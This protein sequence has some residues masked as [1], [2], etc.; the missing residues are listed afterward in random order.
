LLVRRQPLDQH[1][2]RRDR[3]G[4]AVAL[5]DVA[6]N[7]EPD[8]RNRPR[9]R[10]STII[11]AMAAYDRKALP[12]TG[13]NGGG[14]RPVDEVAGEIELLARQVDRGLRRLRD[15]KDENRRVAMRAT[16]GTAIGELDGVLVKSLEL[17]PPGEREFASLG[18]D[19]IMR[20]LIGDFA[21][22]CGFSSVDA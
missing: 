11:R 15:E 9:W 5:R 6:P 18:V 14:G 10:L 21:A 7:G 19:S 17:L 22:A 20:R 1:F 3:R 2:R 16:V 12:G 4:V 13:R 8:V